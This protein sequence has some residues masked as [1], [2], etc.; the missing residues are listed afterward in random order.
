MQMLDAPLCG[1]VRKAGMAA[2]LQGDALYFHK[3][4]PLTR[5]PVEVKPGTAPRGFG[6]QEGEPRLKPAALRPLPEY[7]VRGLGVHI[8]Q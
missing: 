2:I 1:R 7:L 3:S 8:H 4:A 6:P 5:F